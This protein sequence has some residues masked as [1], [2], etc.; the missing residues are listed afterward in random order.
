MQIIKVYFL[1][2]KDAYNSFQ[3]AKRLIEKGKFLEAAMLLEAAKSLEPKKGSIR[4]ALAI[5]YYNCGLHRSAK[6]NFAIALDIDATNDFAHYG[7]GLCL[8][9][10]REIKK[11]VGH[12]KI[13]R[14]MK[15]GSILYQKILKKME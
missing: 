9:K 10:E 15:P 13:A 5:S 12:F 7:L 4:E 1:Q 8:L 11:A 2:M 6:K 14:S 3:K